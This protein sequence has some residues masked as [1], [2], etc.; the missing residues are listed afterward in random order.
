MLICGPLAKLQR[1]VSAIKSKY[2]GACPISIVQ[3]LRVAGR[4]RMGNHVPPFIVCWHPFKGLAR[5]GFDRCQ[6]PIKLLWM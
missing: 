3:V 2:S 1:T 4:S 6:S 5:L